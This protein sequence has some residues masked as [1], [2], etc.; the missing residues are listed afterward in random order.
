MAVIAQAVLAV[1]ELV[2]MVALVL[3]LEPVQVQPTEA[4]AVVAQGQMIEAHREIVI[5][6]LEG[7]S[8]VVR[9]TNP[10][11]AS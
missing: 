10:P 2:G 9:E 7:N 8:I 11:A 3:I 6:R 4:Q 5:V 1:P